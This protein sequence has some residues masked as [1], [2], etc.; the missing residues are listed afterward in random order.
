MKVQKIGF[1]LIWAEKMEY[2]DLFPTRIYKYS[3]RDELIDNI[4][5]N[6]QFNRTHR[7]DKEI[8][9]VEDVLNDPLFLQLHDEVLDTVQ[10]GLPNT[11]AVGK[12]KIVTSWINLQKP[13]QTGFKYHSHIDS[14]MSCVL[15]LKGTDM[16]LAFKDTPRQTTP[17]SVENASNFEIVVR[18]T[19]HPD[20]QIP[21]SAG[22]L[23]MFPSYLVHKPNENESNDD[24]ISLAYNLFP[25]RVKK[26]ESGLN[27]PWAMD[28][29]I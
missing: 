3:I 25:S 7:P 13:N 28:F 26:S 12:W 29:E 9:V 20:V 24:R 16:H 14:F 22:D 18:H 6:Y 11:Y 5:E 2:L 10:D 19:W 1:F 23:S 4:L 17:A 27:I 8:D 21:V 15:Y